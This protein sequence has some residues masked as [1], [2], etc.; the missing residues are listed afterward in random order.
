MAIDETVAIVMPLYNEALV[1]AG[2]L[3]DLK[4]HFKYVVCI[5][6]GSSDGSASIA[7]GTGAIV[8]RH[9]YNLGQGAALQT[10]IEFVIRY[11]PV[12]YVV[13]FDS[14]G[15]HQVNDVIGML[16]FSR[17][18]D[19][20]IVFG[21]RFLDARSNPSR[22]KRL[23]LKVATVLTNFST[24]LKL[25]DAHNGLR[26]MH[27]AAF[28][29]LSLKQNRMAHGTEIVQQLGQMKLSWGEYPVQVLYTDYS[30]AKGQSIFN[31]VNIIFDL[32][33]K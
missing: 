28:E 18:N 11:L 17:S 13:T 16:N 9:P 14:D 26:L 12:D 33:V 31:S 10:G 21:S 2:V 29:Q 6:D 7:Q 4:E 15:Q 22:M 30:K 23:V 8:I 1:V 5:D 27:R 3:E 25:T 19:L 20:A 24:G 32:L